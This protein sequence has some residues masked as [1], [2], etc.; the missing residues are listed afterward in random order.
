MP[1]DAEAAYGRLGARIAEAFGSDPQFAAAAPDPAVSALLRSPDTGLAEVVGLVMNNYRDRAAL[2]ERAVEL[3]TDPATGRVDA[4]LLERFDTITYGEL[5]ERVRALARTLTSPHVHAGDRIAVLGFSSIDYVTIDLAISHVGGVAVPL[6]SSALL[7][8]LKPIVTETEPVVIASSV[9]ALG[10]AV[11]LAL[12]SHRL[13]RL[14]VFDYNAAVDDHRDALATGMT[15]LADAD[16]K[17]AIETLRNAIDRGSA[18]PDVAPPASEDPNELRLLIYTSGSTGTPKG[19]VYSERLVASQWR[20]RVHVPGMAELPVITLN[21]MPLSHTAGRS[22]LYSTLGNGGTAYFAASNDSSTL[23]DD[24]AL[25]RPT[26]MTFVPRI[27]EMI[28]DSYQASVPAEQAGQIDAAVDLDAMAAHRLHL[29]GNRYYLAVNVSAPIT[30]ELK[31]WVELYLDLPLADGYASTESGLVALNGQIL[32]PPTIDYKLVDVPELGYFITDRPYPRGELLMKSEGMFGGYYGRPDLTA[33]VFDADGFYRTGDIVAELGPDQVRYL[34]RRNNVLKLSQGEFV[35]A[36]K[37]EIAYSV[38]DL[39]RQIY[40]YA[41]SARA[42]LLAVIVP[43]DEAMNRSG[44]DVSALKALLA[45]ALQNVAAAAGLRSYEIPRDFVIETEPFTVENGLLTGIRKQARPKLKERYGAALEQLYTD[46]AEGQAKELG[47]LRQGATERPVIDTVARAAAALLGA[48]SSE[49]SADAHFAELG[50]DSLSALTFGNQLND[51]FDIQ[52]PVG[53]IVSPANDLQAIA[54]YIESMRAGASGRPTFTSVHGAHATQIDAED[55]RLDKFIDAATLDAAPQ[56]PQADSAVR[57][58][59]LTGATGFLGRYLALEWLE[60]MSQVG[61]KVICLVRGTSNDDAR[62][63]L[64]DIFDTVDLNLT[65]HYRILASSHLEVLAGDKG[66]A[67]LGLSAPTWQRLAD[68]VDVIVDPAALV[69]HVLPYSELFEP[70]VV[71]TA[72]LIRL[73]LT[74]K[75]KPYTYVSTV[76]VGLGAAGPDGFTEDADPRTMGKT[77]SLDDNYANGYGNSKWAAEVLLR[78]AHEHAGLP[79]SVFRCGMILADTTYA[80]QLNLPDTLTR[81]IL[82]LV[83]TGIAPESFYELGTD[84]NPQRAHYDGL[85]VEFIAEAISAL[86]SQA[87]QGYQTYHVTNPHDDG[88][89]MDTFVDWLIAAGYEIRRVGDYTDWLARFENALRALPDKQRKASLLPLIHNYQR[90]E[91]PINGSLVPTA[92]FRAA[93]QEAKIGP[94]Q[95]IPHVTAPMIVKYVFDLQLLGQL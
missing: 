53:V 91:H 87:R 71:G 35:A 68:T 89:G 38:S 86:G 56:L 63:R 80:G 51:I 43:S 72:E 8:Q 30:P 75:T 52:V 20:P 32:R 45:R 42:Y 73:A 28:Y 13:A 66:Q 64:D 22:S 34:D 49:V 84:G 41:N 14:V 24:L 47:A 90:P 78:E 6:Q 76:A 7:A 69:N 27:W 85:S 25:V 23:L 3:T 83:A 58:V 26:S 1:L 15:R 59:L 36:E 21:F 81:M 54:D 50:G 67:S 39:V 2:A 31:E 95:D 55:L 18:L 62:A 60:R 5:W 12:T 4:Q 70:N 19:A 48:A 93:V 94:S 79:V 40:I 10:T 17:I 57:T 16:E 33:D 65:A 9:A 82:S 88:V 11:E 44:G 29:V 37:V 61:G 74:T 46:L 92:R 77:R